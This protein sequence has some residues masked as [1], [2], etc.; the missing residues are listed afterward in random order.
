[1]LMLL[2]GCGT[3]IRPHVSTGERDRLGGA[4]PA[5]R[6]GPRLTPENETT[7]STSSPLVD[8]I[9]RAHAM[10]SGW[11]ATR[12]TEDAGACPK[13]TD[14][15]N[16]LNAAVIERYSHLPVGATMVVCADQPVPRDWQRE[17]NRDVRATCPGARVQEG[18]P[19]VLVI[20]RVSARS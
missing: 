6:L 8:Q 7:G 10:R 14:P 9:C 13:S 5:G 11:L 16:S 20:R 18:A 15:E 3:T 19:T 17:Y 4:P 1:M 2:V 12:Y